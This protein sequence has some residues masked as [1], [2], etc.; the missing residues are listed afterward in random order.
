MSNFIS[1]LLS[2]FPLV[3]DLFQQQSDVKY[4]NVAPLISFLSSL[5]LVTTASLLPLVFQQTYMPSIL[6]TYSVPKQITIFTK[7]VSMRLG[8]VESVSMMAMTICFTDA[9]ETV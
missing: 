2:D 4:N 5:F 7:P 6:Q 8:W 3:S 1:G 9:T